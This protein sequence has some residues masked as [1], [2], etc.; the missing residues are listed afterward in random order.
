MGPLIA[1]Y[2]ITYFGGLE[3]ADSFRPLFAFQ[4]LVGLVVFFMSWRMLDDV[5]ISRGGGGTGLSDALHSVF[6]GSTTLKILFIRDI[7]LSFFASMSRPFLGIY[8]VDE[9][10]ATAFI[11]GY[12]GASEMLVDVFLSIP[13]GKVISKYGRRRIAYAGHLVGVLARCILFLIPRSHPEVLVLYAVL[14]SVEGCMYLGW[15]AFAL[16]VVPQEVRGKYLGLRAV[17][18]GM[19]GVLAPILGGIVWNLNPDYLWWI[20]ALQ[21]TLIAFPLMVIAMQRHT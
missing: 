8:Q 1:A 21:W 20:D 7:I 13:M 4:F 16:E 18:V 9:K 19:V 6:R 5:R 10:M 2:I 11:L 3:Y 15:D 14:G 17:M 12:M